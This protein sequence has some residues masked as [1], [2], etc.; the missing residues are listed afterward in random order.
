MSVA[1]AIISLDIETYNITDAI[2]VEEIRAA[3]IIRTVSKNKHDEGILI[4]NLTNILINF[5]HVRIVKLTRNTQTYNSYYDYACQ[6]FNVYGLCSFIKS[7]STESVVL[8][9]EDIILSSQLQK[10]LKLRFEKIIYSYCTSIENECINLLKSDCISANITFFSATKDITA[11]ERRHIYKYYYSKAGI[12]KYEKFCKIFNVCAQNNNVLVEKNNTFT[13]CSTD[14]F[15]MY[16]ETEK[17]SCDVILKTIKNISNNKNAFHTKYDETY[18]S[19]WK[20]YYFL[21]QC[22]NVWLQTTYFVDR[23]G[24]TGIS[25]DILPI[26][27]SFMIQLFTKNQTVDWK[28]VVTFIHYSDMQK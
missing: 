25:N 3:K 2:C 11:D 7:Y 21:I 19:L 24:V 15:F 6:K 4:K 22:I 5:L 17:Y 1:R 23:L 9:I 27:I 20:K 28:Q 14:T 8:I 12:I 16:Y 18:M 13:I 10:E 26:I